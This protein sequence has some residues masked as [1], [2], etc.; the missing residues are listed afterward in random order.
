[1]YTCIFSSFDCINYYYCSLLQNCSQGP[2]PGDSIR[3]EG[4]G[5]H[6]ASTSSCLQT[7]WWSS[8]P[9]MSVPKTCCGLCHVSA[10]SPQELIIIIGLSRATSEIIMLSEDHELA[11]TSSPSRTGRSD[12]RRPITASKPPETFVAHQRTTKRSSLL[13]QPDIDQP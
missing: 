1:M 8:L 10:S 5:G 12:Y 4:K 9:C 11:A 7:S 3:V 2:F 13:K 6:C